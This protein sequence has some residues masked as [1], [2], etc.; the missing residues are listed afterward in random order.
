MASSAKLRVLFVGQLTSVH[1]AR[2]LSQIDTEKVE[3][4]LYGSGG[5]KWVHPELEDLLS[6]ASSFQLNRRQ[7]KIDFW[8][9][10]FE[11]V[12]GSPWFRSQIL[13]R[14][15]K[16]QGFD[17]VH[18]FD[19]Q[20]S[21]YLMLPKFSAWKKLPIHLIAS[22]W[23]S[24]LFWYRN[25]R[26]HRTKL[27]RCL[28]LI[29]FYTAECARDLELS[30]E[31]GFRGK[32]FLILNGGGIEI[33]EPSETL[34]ERDVIVVKGYQ[35]RFGQAGEILDLISANT[36]LFG[37]YKI[38]FLSAAPAIRGRIS[39]MK[40]LTGLDMSFESFGDNRYP[41]NLEDLRELF[42]ASRI[43][44][45]K[46]KS[47]GVATLALEALSSGCMP[48]QSPTSCLSEYLSL[49]T[50]NLQPKRND[51]DSFRLSIVEALSIQDFELSEMAFDSA[52]QASSLISKPETKVKI[53]Q[54][55]AEVK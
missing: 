31:L 47:D 20:N 19:F 48:I 1:F 36:E 2:W 14:I 32:D 26:R 43:L 51:I 39:S 5:N 29:D 15:A 44:I 4:L 13:L 11:R 24:D 17:A 16:W 52:R 42:S 9:S 37:G 12:L 38:V 34:T 22:N 45:S 33:L 53:N 41:K 55:Y 3:G 40:E 27:M 30:R 25:V 7:L 10:K 49:D 46:S 21:A 23:G 28:S 54:L 18:F 50:R 35:D 8:L 6:A